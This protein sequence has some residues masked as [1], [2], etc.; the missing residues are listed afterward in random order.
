MVFFL[1]KFLLLVIYYS[2]SHYSPLYSIVFLDF[3]DENYSLFE[4]EVLFFRILGTI[5]GML[6]YFPL[7]FVIYWFVLSYFLYFFLIFM[8]FR[9]IFCL[10]LG[11]VLG[12][13]RD[14]LKSC[15][16]FFK[17]CYA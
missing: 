1:T 8:I 16:F 6:S 9:S 13:F 3:L 4:I 5:L 14:F 10:C 7:I 2:I 12:R 17:S 15:D 11:S